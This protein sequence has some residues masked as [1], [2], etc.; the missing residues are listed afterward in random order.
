M[1][2]KSKE[3]VAIPDLL[4]KKA[5]REKITALTAYD[6]PTAKI[7]DNAGIDIILVGDSL[8]MVVLG[9]ENTIPVTM[10]M[11]IHH[12]RAVTR[13]TKKALV[14]GDMPFFSYNVSLEEAKKNA[15]R[16]IQEAGAGAVKIEG[17]SPRRLQLISSLVEADIPV[18]GHVGLTPQAIH[19]LGRFQVKGKN[20]KEARDILAQARDLEGAGVFSVVLECIPRELAG[21][22]TKKLNI[23]TIGIG[24]GP[25]CDGQILVFH[26][27]AGYSHGY[28]P[29][30][31]KQYAG[32]ND[33]IG[34]AVK[35]YIHDV[36]KN[37]FPEDKHCYHLKNPSQ[38]DEFLNHDEE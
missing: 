22:V 27:L 14:V 35:N 28:L 29:K 37:A 24:A 9:Y 33:V 5:S 11:M 2:A 34:N 32:L 31:V 18:M 19:H 23:P 16:F 38:L 36:K 20:R 3:P 21:E 7:M 10:D 1:T 13:G 12:T 4:K 30:F 8:G 6:F 17:S 26:D 15:C 25:H